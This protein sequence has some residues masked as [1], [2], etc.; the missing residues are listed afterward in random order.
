MGVAPALASVGTR[1]QF[2]PPPFSLNKRLATTSCVTTRLNPL[3][4]KRVL[5]REDK[6][7]LRQHTTQGVLPRSGRATRKRLPLF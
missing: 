5:T 4:G 2:P 3:V 7:I 6:A 1:V